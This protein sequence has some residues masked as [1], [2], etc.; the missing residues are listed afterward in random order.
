LLGTLF[1][2]SHLRQLSFQ[3]FSKR[4]LGHGRAVALRRHRDR[5]RDHG[6]IL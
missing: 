1:L 6:R 2:R 4:L 5:R 3:L